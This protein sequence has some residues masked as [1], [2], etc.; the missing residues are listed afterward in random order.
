MPQVVFKPTS[1]RRT[2]DTSVDVTYTLM[3]T[4]ALPQPRV[5]DHCGQT[6]DLIF[7]LSIPATNEL[8]IDLLQVRV[9]RSRL[10]F[11]CCCCCCVQHTK[12]NFK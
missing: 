2:G 12:L 9:T 10:G 4:P 8:I 6:H 11:F 7:D 1:A 5:Y 3:V